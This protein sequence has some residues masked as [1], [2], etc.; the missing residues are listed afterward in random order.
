MAAAAGRG[1][2]P[3]CEADR[4]APRLRVL[5]GA[6]QAATEFGALARIRALCIKALG[7]LTVA[8]GRLVHGHARAFAAENAVTVMLLP[9]V[10]TR[11]AILISR[12]LVVFL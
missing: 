9:I 8:T 11:P 12:A 10:P 5:R 7:V 6:G 2:T 4:T 1:G 3:D